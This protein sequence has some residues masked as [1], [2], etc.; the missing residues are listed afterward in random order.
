[1]VEKDPGLPREYLLRAGEEPTLVITSVEDEEIEDVAVA[2]GAV[3]VKIEEHPLSP[4][5][6]YNAII[7]ASMDTMLDSVYEYQ[8]VLGIMELLKVSFSEAISIRHEGTEREPEVE[9][10]G[11]V[12]AVAMGG[13]DFRAS[14]F[15][16]MKKA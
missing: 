8:A 9:E 5:M 15:S 10:E 3:D 2:D 6:A 14:M 16:I 7:V 4:E 13:S 12:E 11:I 1:M